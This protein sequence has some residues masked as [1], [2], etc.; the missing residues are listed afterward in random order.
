MMVTACAFIPLLNNR[1]G[2][3]GTQ[4]AV[5]STILWVAGRHALQRTPIQ[6]GEKRL[7]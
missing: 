1:E 6:F 2:L 7:Q 3:F 4:K 5:L